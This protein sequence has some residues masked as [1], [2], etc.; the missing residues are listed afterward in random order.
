MLDIEGNTPVWY[1]GHPRFD[2]QPV[3]WKD[4]IPFPESLVCTAC[5]ATSQRGG[6]RSSDSRVAGEDLSPS[7]G[8]ATDDVVVDAEGAQDLQSEVGIQAVGG[9]AVV[10]VSA[11]IT[12]AGCVRQLHRAELY[13]AGEC[14]A[15]EILLRSC[16][17]STKCVVI[18]LRTCIA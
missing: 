11:I 18:V 13:C 4:G 10:D 12:A 9:E 7:Y 2:P 1:Q 17:A 8:A 3:V 16:M 15:P 5:P 6:S 14:I